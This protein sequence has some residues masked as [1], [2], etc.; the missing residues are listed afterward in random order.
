MTDSAPEIYSDLVSGLLTAEADRRTTLEAKGS[1]VITT[2][3][4]LVTLLFGLVALV[5][6]SEKFDLPTAAHG[7]LFAAI[8]GFVVACGAAIFVSLPLP[9]GETKLTAQ[10]LITWWDQA[11]DLALLAVSSVRLEAL[12]AARRMNDVKV[13]ILFVATIAL[14]VALFLL[15]M[16]VLKILEG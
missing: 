4:T 3:G 7:W 13:R 14:V 5:D 6:G 11:P 8:C 15:G 10:Q 1:A 16:T 2:A 9:Y 12:A